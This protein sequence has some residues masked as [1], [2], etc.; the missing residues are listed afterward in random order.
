MVWANPLLQKFQVWRKDYEEERFDFLPAPE[1]SNK[2]VN[3]SDEQ[4]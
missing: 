1:L 2:I 4:L 3:I